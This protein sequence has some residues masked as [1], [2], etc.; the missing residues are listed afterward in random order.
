MRYLLDADSIWSSSQFSRHFYLPENR[1][2]ASGAER[3][4]GPARRPERSNRRRIWFHG[5]SVG[6]IHL[7]RGVVASFRERHPD[8]ECYVSSTTDGGFSEAQK[9]FPDLNVVRWPLDFSWAVDRAIREVRPDLIVLAESDLWPNFLLS[10]Q[11]HRIPVVAINVRLSPRSARR[12]HRC[13]SLARRLLSLVSHFAVQTEQYAANLRE[14]GVDPERLTVTGSV[15]YDGVEANRSN[16]KTVELRRL[17]GISASE[18][19]WVAGSTM[20]PEEEIVF[21]VYGRLRER[22]SNLRLIIVPRQPT[23]FEPTAELLASA[24]RLRTF[25][26]RSSA[27]IRRCLMGRSC[28]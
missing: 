2:K 16:G 15:K 22:H 14:V 26:A 8:C 10:A 28:C 17:F 11:R 9:S 3:L 20:E 27:R 23:R 1:A 12:F 21:D 7:L 19:V 24:A 6:E 25:A 13:R 4:V 5:V 18:I